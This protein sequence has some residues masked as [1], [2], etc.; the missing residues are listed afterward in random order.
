MQQQQEGEA[1]WKVGVTSL[2]EEWLRK[3]S[4]LE[5]FR[6]KHGHC[7]VP[8]RYMMHGRRGL[9]EWVRK[10]RREC[11]NYAQDPSSSRLTAEHVAS[12]ERVGAIASWAVYKPHQPTTDCTSSRAPKRR[13]VA[14]SSLSSHAPKRFKRVRSSAPSIISL[15][16][17]RSRAD[18]S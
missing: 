12:L 3:L 2:G 14:R 17:K 1:S 18:L 6:K 16:R 7:N 8:S 10:Q 15:R 9:G 11:M 5:A 13:K 4:G